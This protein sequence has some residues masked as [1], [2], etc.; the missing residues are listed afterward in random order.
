MKMV[1]DLPNGSSTRMNGNVKQNRRCTRKNKFRDSKQG[2]G[3]LVSEL[4]GHSGGIPVLPSLD[5]AAVLDA[6]DGGAG[7]VGDFAG[8]DVFTFGEPVDAGQIAFGQ[9]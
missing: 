9:R 4:S 7:D 6:D 1:T 3:R 2:L 8:G 5:E